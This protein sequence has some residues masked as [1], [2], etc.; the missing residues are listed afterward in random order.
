MARP[1]AN[2]LVLM[3]TDSLLA[4]N[5]IQKEREASLSGKAPKSGN[6]EHQEHR[7]ATKSQL[8]VGRLPSWAAELICP[9]NQGFDLKHLLQPSGF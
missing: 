6:K 5:G 1:P 3:H 8:R 4:H 7:V 9:P 2:T